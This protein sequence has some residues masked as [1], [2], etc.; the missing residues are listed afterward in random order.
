MGLGREA[1]L[2]A[3]AP[4]LG[5]ELLQL[6]HLKEAPSVVDVEGEGGQGGPLGRGW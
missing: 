1:E 4:V 3:E 5:D 6:A 2:A